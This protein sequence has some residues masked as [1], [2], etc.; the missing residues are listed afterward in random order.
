MRFPDFLRTTVLISAAAAT[1]LAAVTLAGSSGANDDLLVPF[2]AGWWVFAAVIGAW[3]GRRGTTSSPI[4]SLLAGARTQTTLPELDPGRTVLNRL[5][6]LLVVT[7]RRRRAGVHPAA[8]A[9]RRA[10]F[11][12][13]WALAWRRQASA[14]TAIE[15]RDG[16]R[17]YVERTSPLQPIRLVRTPGFRSNLFELQRPLGQASRAAR[18][19]SLQW[20]ART[21]WSSRSAAR[22][23]G[24]L[25][26]SELAKSIARAGAT[27]ELA[28]ARP[29][30]TG[31]HDGA[32][33]LRGG[34]T[35]PRGLPARDRRARPGAIIYCSVTAS[36]LWPRPGAIS[37]DSIA[38]ENRP[39]RHG[40]WQRVVERRRLRRRRWCS[41]WSE[42]SLE[43]LRGEHADVVVAPPPVEG[44]P[45]TAS[46]T[47]PRSRTP[48]TR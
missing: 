23:A 40:I 17:F 45:G 46:A 25:R 22:P 42:R 18:A 29:A 24:V 28:T 12:I 36:L 27:V 19:P 9:G 2:A 5:W 48:G 30:A 32:D 10:G 8:G 44:S 3:L 14:V 7:D 35:R 20:P 1:A 16:A 6:P 4:A 39:G 47:S 38:A 37:L 31:P 21:S 43:P 41:C 34:A 26:P 11:A 15:E 33:R 13:I